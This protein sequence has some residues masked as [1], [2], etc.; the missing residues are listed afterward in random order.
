VAEP[1]TPADPRRALA[2]EIAAY[3]DEGWEAPYD[4]KRLLA[5]AQRL[6]SLPRERRRPGPGGDVTDTVETLADAAEARAG[7]QIVNLDW[8]TTRSSNRLHHATLTDQ[9]AAVMYDDRSL[10]GPIKLACGRTVDYVTIPDVF[11]RIGAQRC[12]GC[13]NN[14]G[15]PPGKGSPKNNPTCRRLLGLETS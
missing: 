10:T 7:R 2:E 15:Y 11:T 6:L 9:Q 12:H 14:L 5:A 1:T 13:C 4:A 8:V 3:L